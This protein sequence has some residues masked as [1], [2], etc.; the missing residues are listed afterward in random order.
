MVIH[1]LSLSHTAV[2]GTADLEYADREAEAFYFYLG[3]HFEDVRSFFA[4]LRSET[5]EHSIECSSRGFQS[6]S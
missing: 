6:A 3:G 1:I 4:G 5:L 2:P